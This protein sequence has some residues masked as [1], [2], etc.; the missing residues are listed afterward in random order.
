MAYY[1]VTNKR[2]WRVRTVFPHRGIGVL[3]APQRYSGVILLTQFMYLG[4]LM[5]FAVVMIAL[6]IALAVCADGYI[7]LHKRVG[8]FDISLV[9]F[10]GAEPV[11]IFF[12]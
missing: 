12:L 3:C 5:A 2:A 7:M 1:I 9:D 4:I 8:N 10:E 11:T 6:G